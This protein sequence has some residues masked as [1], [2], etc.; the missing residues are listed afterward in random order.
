[1]KLSHLH[2]GGVLG[3]VVGILV[4][5]VVIYGWAPPPNTASALPQSIA[6]L[7][8]GDYLVAAPGRVEPASEEINVGAAVTGVLSEVVVKEGQ[9]VHKGDVL[10]LVENDDYAAS[11][12]RAQSDVKLYEAE[13]LRV[14]NGARA[15]ERRQAMAAV[16][17]TEAVEANMKS[18][19][20]RQR[21]LAAASV[22]SRSVL[23]KAEADLIV[24]HQRHQQAVEHYGLVNDSARDEDVAI[25]QAK[26]DAAKASVLEAQAILNKTIIRSPIDGTIL[27]IFRHPGELLSV[28]ALNPILLLG[29]TSKL[30]VRVEV[31]EADIAKVT[32]GMPAYVTADAYG[33]RR[34]TGS[35]L[36][37]GQI[38]GKKNIFT[39]E[40][41][42]RRDTRVLE[43]LITL[44]MPNPLLPGLRV[45]AFIVPQTVANAQAAT[46]IGP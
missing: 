24:A 35:V 32:T 3:L 19:V 8:A 4:E 23:D 27:R 10:A 31:D 20:E 46:K 9:F 25:A 15:A 2:L 30:S 45:T 42:E 21:K 13:L 11:L 40:P 34:F 18:D 44:D 36:R 1:M 7:I 29:D 37:V 22:V 14:N 6:P 33:D 17:E 41:T 43:T 28:F 16:Q 39:E 12:N 26:L 5:V 38:L